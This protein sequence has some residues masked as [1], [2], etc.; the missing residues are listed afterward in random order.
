MMQH[1]NLSQLIFDVGFPKNASY[2]FCMYSILSKA[3]A[4]THKP[5][6]LA[7]SVFCIHDQLQTLIAKHHSRIA[8]QFFDAWLIRMF[9]L[10]ACNWISSCNVLLIHQRFRAWLGNCVRKQQTW[11]KD[12]II[13]IYDCTEFVFFTATHIIIFDLDYNLLLKAHELSQRPV[14]YLISKVSKIFWWSRA[15][16]IWGKKKATCNLRF[17]K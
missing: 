5:K 10:H 16:D 11:P 8:M 17:K 4:F 1:E 15:E 13:I 9:F 12:G 2:A 7:D 3:Y 6:K 14:A